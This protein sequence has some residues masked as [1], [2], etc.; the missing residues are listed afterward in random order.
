[1]T[2]K[3]N[4]RKEQEKEKKEERKKKKNFPLIEKNNKSIWKLKLRSNG[5]VIGNFKRK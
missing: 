3:G 2:L 5:G 1:M 4:R